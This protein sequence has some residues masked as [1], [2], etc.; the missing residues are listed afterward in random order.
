MWIVYISG[1]IAALLF[2][3]NKLLKKWLNV[4]GADFNKQYDQTML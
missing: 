1:I 3:A 2:I 4:P